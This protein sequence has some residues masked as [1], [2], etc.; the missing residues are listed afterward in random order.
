MALQIAPS[1]LSADF[2]NLESEI[3]RLEEAGSHMFH[4][5]VMDGHFVKNITMGPCVISS[6]RSKTSLPFDVH[7][8]ISSP[9]LYLKDF[10]NAGADIITVHY[11]AVADLPAVLREIRELG[12]RAG[13]SI[14]PGTNPENIFSVLDLC[15][16]VLVMSVYPGFSGQSFIESQLVVIKQVSDE[17]KR[18]DLNVLIEV[19]GGINDVTAKEAVIAGADILVSGNYIVKSDNSKN[20]IKT[21]LNYNIYHQKKS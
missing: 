11:E 19:D 17:I 13:V 8:M 15:D 21:L 18:R 7:L 2:S 14:V 5:D 16:I 3:R 4:I 12:C 10:A 20:A 6:V 9:E 1:I